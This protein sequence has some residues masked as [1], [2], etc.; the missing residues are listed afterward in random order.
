MN[1]ASLLLPANA[2]SYQAGLDHVEPGLDRFLPR[3][4]ELPIR[5]PPTIRCTSGDLDVARGDAG[6]TPL[7]ELRKK[8]LLVFLYC[9][10][11]N[12][13]VGDRST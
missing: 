12:I 1:C 8:E 2:L 10:L 13:H 6:W 3:R 5:F 4:I 7:L 11:P 9:I